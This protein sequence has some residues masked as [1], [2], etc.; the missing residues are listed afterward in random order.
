MAGDIKSI[1]NEEAVR[2]LA[3]SL[4]DI[5]SAFDRGGFCAASNAGL[6]NLELTQ[7][8]RHIANCL[9]HFL[10]QP[11]TRAAGLLIR[12]LGPEVAPTGE[13][14]PSVLRYFPH[15]FF[16]AQFG[17]DDFEAAMAAQYEL[18]KRFTAEF[19]IRSF[20]E[21]YPEQ[22]Y[23]QLQLWA[24]DSNPHV[25]RLVSEGTRPRLPWAPR[26][27]DYQRD[28]APVIAL[29]EK[30]RDDPS[31][32]VRRSVA[33]SINDIAKDH[34]DIAVKL[35]ARWIKGADGNR[36]W[37][38]KHALRGLIKQGHAGALAVLG[39]KA[40]ALVQVR[41]LA[42]GEVPVR[43][44]ERLAFSCTVSAQGD[45][46]ERLVVDFA[47]HFMKSSGR[48]SRKVFKLKTLTLKPRE[49]VRLEGRVSFAELT[50]RRHYPGRHLL[51]II[52]NGAVVA[53][54]RFNVV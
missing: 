7:R 53:T 42:L 32:Y 26:L 23:Q 37:L 34:P 46:S 9:N 47:I 41:N 12:S 45:R 31:L 48:T 21:R 14:G 29:L 39:A 2:W 10:P 11:F 51:E 52:V 20:I 13:N 50:T 33:N 4:F 1:L 36:R 44:G 30:L 6:E 22:T 8:A 5:D 16:I 38:V 15:V 27:R 24:A 43:L 35:C 3:D 17:L 54:R 40:G 19:S 28:P 25:R 18:T 49:T